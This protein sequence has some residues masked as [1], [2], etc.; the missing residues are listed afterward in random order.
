MASPYLTVLPKGCTPEQ[1]YRATEED[2]ADGVPSDGGGGPLPCQ[3]IGDSSITNR[4]V[5]FLPADEIIRRMELAGSEADRVRQGGGVV[6]ARAT[7]RGVV[8][9]GKVTLL[10]GTMTGDPYDGGRLTGT[11][12]TSLP[13]V[14]R[15]ADLDTIP[16]GLG[17]GLLL[18]TSVGEQ[19]EW[20]L[21]THTVLVRA[22]SGPLTETQGERLQTAVGDA[23]YVHVERGFVDPMRIV[24]AVLL[25]LFTV[26]LLVI[27]LTSAGLSLAEQEN[28][29]AT[30][31][32]VG[33]D[34]RTRRLMAGAQSFALAVVGVLL[35]VA[36]GLVPGIAITY[37]LTAMSFDP[38]TGESRTGE[39][40]LVIPWVSLLVMTLVVPLVAGAL[41]SLAVRRSPTATRRTT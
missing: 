34:R 20:P 24:T 35:G 12:R 19:H 1:T 23:G 36:V 6:L 26:L 3:A 40:V 33:A 22:A 27:T 28:D 25:G 37:P 41:A 9:E 16:R 30:L 10:S 8:V 39:G 5:V 15:A 13:V 4:S 31:A 7:D 38:A 18:P 11:S 14:V 29:Q 21:T 32:A 2:L 17:A